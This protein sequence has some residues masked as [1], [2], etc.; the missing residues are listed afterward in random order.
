MRSRVNR[1]TSAAESRVPLVTRTGKQVERAHVFQHVDQ[2]G[3]QRRFTA[4][5]EHDAQS[6]TRK[7]CEDGANLRAR[8]LIPPAIERQGAVAARRVAA[9]VDLKDGEQRFPGRQIAC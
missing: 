4:L 9:Q 3:A 6:T 2:V 7:P 1:A 5:D 8:H